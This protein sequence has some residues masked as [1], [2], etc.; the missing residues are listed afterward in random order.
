MTD[1]ATQ[2]HGAIQR[3]Q[4]LDVGGLLAKIVSMGITAD[5]AGAVKELVLLHEHRQDRE[6]RQEFVQAFARARANMKTIN[7]TKGI[8]GSTKGV[9]R[10][11]YTPL[12][13]LQ[14]A[15]EPIL[16][17]EGLTLR[18]DSHRDG[19]ICTGIC[20]LYHTSGHA[21]KSE[22]AVGVAGCEGGDLGA[23]KKAKRGALTA[24]CGLKTRHMEDDASVLGD[25]ITQEQAESLRERVEKLRIANPS[26][27]HERFL[28]MAD[29]KDYPEIRTGK[30]ATLDAALR[31]NE[32][33]GASGSAPPPVADQ[34][35]PPDGDPR[36]KRDIAM[37]FSENL[38]LDDL[39]VFLA[40][41]SSLVEKARASAKTDA[42][43]P[44]HILSD[45]K[46]REVAFYVKLALLE[47]K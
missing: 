44:L 35:A 7:A 24:M 18:F 8:P 1:L 16:E 12:E 10:W 26:K 9:M 36:T 45:H 19:N 28:K 32:G 40:K 6:Y 39:H 38:S 20:W 31:R 21:E 34:P 46:L 27:T 25:Y 41:N 33:G 30:Y 37:E 42:S 2:N 14:D 23:F 13:E 3:T 5:S 29:A 11:Y 4:E 47:G 43:C 22:C 17:A 15:V